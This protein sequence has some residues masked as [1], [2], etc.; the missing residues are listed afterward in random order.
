MK[1]IQLLMTCAFLLLFPSPV[2][3][4]LFFIISYSLNVIFNSIFFSR[5][6]EAR[7]CEALRQSTGLNITADTPGCSCGINLFSYAV[8]ISCSAQGVICIS[9]SDPTFCT[10]ATGVFSNFEVRSNTLITLSPRSPVSIKEEVNSVDFDT[11]EFF[12]NRFTFKFI[13]GD[14]APSSNKYIGCSVDTV[15]T[16]LTVPDQTSVAGKCNT[17]EICDNGVD[18]KYDCSNVDGIFAFSNVTNTTGILPGPK[19]ENC[20]PVVNVFPKF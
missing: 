7:D 13:H 14:G 2:E 5:R 6:R 17:C 20:F 10:S 19:V 1:S 12:F 4:T 11:P 16:D 9:P 18:F 3:G 15:T 8:D